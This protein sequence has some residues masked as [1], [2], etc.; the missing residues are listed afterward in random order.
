[1]LLISQKCYKFFLV[2][3]HKSEVKHVIIYAWSQYCSYVSTT[4]MMAV[5]PVVMMAVILSHTVS[6]VNA[7]D[8]F[9]ILYWV[10]RSYMLKF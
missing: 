1:M 10:C 8:I 5:A 4:A 3:Q 6:Y 2:V 7:T 9:C